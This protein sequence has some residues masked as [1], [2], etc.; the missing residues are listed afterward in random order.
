M[1]QKK[2]KPSQK[3]VSELRPKNSC[4]CCWMLLRPMPLQAGFICKKCRRREQ[5]GGVLVEAPPQPFQAHGLF[6]DEAGGPMGPQRRAKV[7]VVACVSAMVQALGRCMGQI[8]P[9]WGAAQCYPN[10]K[11]GED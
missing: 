10:A 9:A 8:N 1:S 4:G 2:L 11:F 6:I 5:A 7:E 3:A